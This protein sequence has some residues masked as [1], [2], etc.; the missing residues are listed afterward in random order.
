MQGISNSVR[1]VTMYN[2][3]SSPQFILQGPMNLT[4]MWGKFQELSHSFISRYVAYHNFR[5]KGWVVKTGIKYGADFGN[6]A[7][8][9]F[10]IL[11]G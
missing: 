11:L 6:E 10:R 7:F 4:E 2:C 1:I 3:C 8:S 5:S 9:S